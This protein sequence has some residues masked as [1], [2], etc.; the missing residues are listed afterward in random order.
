MKDHRFNQLRT[1][2]LEIEQVWGLPQGWGSRVAYGVISEALAEQP[3]KSFFP[4]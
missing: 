2:L 1:L 4:I 3:L